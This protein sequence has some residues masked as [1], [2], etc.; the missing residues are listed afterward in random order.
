M[1]NIEKMISDKAADDARW[2]EQRKKE[3]EHAAE[4][5]D[6]GIADITTDPAVYAQYLNL[7]GDNPEYSA[8]NIAMVMTQA[9]EA[10]VFRTIDRWK[11]L[12]R[13]VVDRDPEHEV[14]IFTKAPSGRSYNLTPVYDISQT[15]GRELWKPLLQDDSREME[16]ALASLLRFSPVQVEAD[17][18]LDTVARYDPQAMKLSINPDYSDS[19]VFAAAAAQIA[20]ARFHDRGFN[21]AYSQENYELS[22]Q[23]VSYILCRRFGIEREQPDASRLPELYQGRGVEERQ[24]SLKAIQGMSRQIGGTID[25]AIAPPQRAAPVRRGEAR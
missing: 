25:K 10:T 17:R 20:H 18:D 22:A 14:K 6:V 21:R 15:Q 9:P 12:G 7:Q 8:G 11:A 24:E 23:S 5:R 19:Q 2:R 3:H 1:A 16:A 4:L 13:A